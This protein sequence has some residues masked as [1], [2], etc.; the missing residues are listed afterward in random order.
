MKNIAK[1]T[2]PPVLYLLRNS[3]QFYAS[4]QEK[5]YVLEFDS[6][7]VSDLEV[8]KINLLNDSV[9]LFI[10]QNKIT[11]VP[12][13]T[14]LSPEIC[15]EKTLSAGTGETNKEEIKKFLDM[16]PFENIKS[17]TYPLGKSFKLYA[18]NMDYYEIIE[19]AF[20]KFGFRAEATVPLTMFGSEVFDVNVFKKLGLARQF[21]LS[22]QPAF[23]GM[24]KNKE[25][26]IRKNKR[27]LIMSGVFIVLIGVMMA[28]IVI[29]MRPAKKTVVLPAVVEKP[30]A[31]EP[32]QTASPAARFTAD[33]IKV[34]IQN[35]SGVTG[36]AGGV[37]E[38][39]KAIGFTE[40]TVGNVSGSVAKSN[41][42]Y[43]ASV[44]A[45][46]LDKTITALKTNY[47]DITSLQI[48]DGD[49]GMIFTIGRDLKL[50][51]AP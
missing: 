29:T 24:D 17:K 48:P 6:E 26:V 44:S 8:K 13:T 37:R 12:F 3:L 27:L 10:E 22:G 9:R 39:F 45:E 41:L 18:V 7:T 43:T 51:I 50:K 34:K 1:K 21:S 49:F 20:E 36:A 15:L 4:G 30:V 14:V 35:A 46:L 5:P 33:Q 42:V 11:P 28:M 23:A 31:E 40:I 16:V 32:V 38:I 19:A 25:E 47:P 2:F